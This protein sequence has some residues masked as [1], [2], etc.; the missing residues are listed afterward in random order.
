MKKLIY[1]SFFHVLAVVLLACRDDNSELGHSLVETSF[2]NVFVD[3]CS[4]D[5]S[6]ILL[7]A[8]LT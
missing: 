5:I 3:T 8:M 1:L 4:V 2:R 7:D 6:T